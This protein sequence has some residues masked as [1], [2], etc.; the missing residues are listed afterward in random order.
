MYG[1]VSADYFLERYLRG[2]VNGVGLFWYNATSCAGLPN[3]NRVRTPQGYISAAGY[4]M[5]QVAKNQDPSLVKAYFYNLT[6]VAK[7]DCVGT[8]QRWGPC[9]TSCGLG[10]KRRRYQII[11]HP[12]LGG[13]KCRP[14]H[15]TT[16]CY[17]GP[18]PEPTSAPTE[19]PTAAPTL[20]PTPEPPTI[21]PCTYYITTDCTP[22]TPKPPL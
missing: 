17:G 14:L 20:E 8:W 13:D 21:A 16:S 15:Y 2:V 6:D 4:A 11:R 10:K 22:M 3:C 1:M 5:T 12:Y 18:C 7:K 19:E 9:E